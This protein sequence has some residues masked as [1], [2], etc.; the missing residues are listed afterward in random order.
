M[1]VFAFF[2]PLGYGLTCSTLRLQQ[3]QLNCDYQSIVSFLCTVVFYYLLAISAF[4]V[5]FSITTTKPCTKDLVSAV[6]KTAVTVTV[7]YDLGYCARLFSTC[8]VSASDLYCWTDHFY[9]TFIHSFIFV[10]TFI[11]HCFL[12]LFL[13]D[14]KHLCV[15]ILHYQYLPIEEERTPSIFKALH[16]TFFLL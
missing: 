7:L 9:F 12:E 5:S 14:C 8:I 6:T 10:A 2:R 1:T 4:P 15:E 13:H 16:A 3:H 11:C